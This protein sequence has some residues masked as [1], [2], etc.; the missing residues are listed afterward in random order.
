[1][2]LSAVVFYPSTR[3]VYQPPVGVFRI[4]L[5]PVVLADDG[6]AL[7]LCDVVVFL[8][9][10]VDMAELKIFHPQPGI[11]S[12][13]VAATHALNITRR[14]CVIYFGM[15]LRQAIQALSRRRSL[16]RLK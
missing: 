15:K 1:M 9:A 16:G 4:A 12:Q 6:D 13:E 8:L 7:S 11:D 5:T 14:V 2:S 3:R 10:N